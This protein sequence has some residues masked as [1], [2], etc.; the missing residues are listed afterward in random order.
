MSNAGTSQ[1]NEWRFVSPI[2]IHTLTQ[3]PVSCGRFD[4]Y[5]ELFW[6]GSSNG[7]V[8]S[9][10]PM[11]NFTR[12][13][14]FVVSK[15]S[16]VHHIEPTENAIFTLTDTVLRAT[17][18]QG[19]PL[20]AYS[21]STMERMMALCRLPG[22][23]TFVMGGFQD[24]L[25]L[26]DFV[27]EKE[28]RTTE[29]Q[30]EETAIVIRYNG[31]NTYSADAKGRIHVKNPKN[32]E[33][34]Q[35][36]GCHNE[37]VLDFDVQGSMMV[38][39]GV[40]LANSSRNSDKFLKVYDLRMNKHLPP[41]SI[42]NS[43]QFVRFIPSY[44][45]R[46]AVVYQTFYNQDGLDF[47][48]NCWNNHPAGI[49]MFDL[50]AP[51]SP[52]EFPIETSLVTSFDYSST[53][54]YLA[55]GNNLGFVNFFADRDQPIIN[56]NSK[57]TVFSVP[58]VQPPLSFVIDDMSHSVG[59]IPMPFPHDPLVSDWP[60]EFTQ[61]V[62]RRRKEP[63]ETKNAKSIHYATQITNP[64]IGT[65]LKLFNIVPYF[66]EQEQPPIKV[67]ADQILFDSP[68]PTIDKIKV[69]KLYKKRPPPVSQI[70]A[71][72]GKAPEEP[73]EAYTWNVIRHVTMQSTHAMNLVA[74]AVV[75]VVYYLGALRNIVLR[76]ICT[77]DSCITCEI[78][79]IFTA[80]SSKIGQD[81]GIATTNLA[82]ALARNGVS[83]KTGGVLSAIQQVI[84]IIL[85][86]VANKVLDTSSSVLT[87][88]DRHLRCIRCGELQSVEQRSEH[89]LTLNYSS[90][91]PSSFCRIL[92]K[93]LHLGAD[94]GER[95]CAEC[96]QISRMECKRKILNLSPVLLINTNTSS[97]RYLDFWQTQLSEHESRPR[98]IGS[99]AFV[100][101]SPSEKK[102]C[103]F[104]DGCRDKRSCKFV[105][106]HIDWSTE[107]TRLLDDIDGIGWN[108]YIPSRI[109]A[110]V[111]EG[112]VRITDISDVPAYEEPNA[113]IYELDAMVH[114]IG[115]GQ[116]D[117][118]WTHPVTLLRESPV[119]STA[120]TLINE[121]LVSRLHDHE[122]RHV[123]P[124]WKLPALIAYKQKGAEV[125]ITE[126][127]VSDDLFFVEKNYAIRSAESMAIKT[128]EDL[129][130]K[131]ELVGLDA[132]FIKI[133]TNL[134]EFN[135]R[136]V[137]AKALGRASCLDVTGEKVI[138]DDHIKL[139]EDLEVVDYLTKYSG[140][141]ES[142][143]CPATSDKYL[144]THKR[145]LL[146]MHVMIQ[147][148]VIF[149]GHAVHNDFSVMNVHIAEPQIIDT[150][151]LWR[152]DA[153][154]MLSLQFLVK[155]VLGESIQ[156]FSHDSV[157][158]AKYTLKLYHKYLEMKDTEIFGPEMR[159]MYAIMPSSC[160]SPNPCAS[161]LTVSTLRQATD[162]IAPP[163]PKSV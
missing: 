101:E 49:K 73:V 33:T 162:E 148:G 122:A 128:S 117:V 82:W 20:T 55:V 130:K 77:E 71:R 120:W 57:E 88:F 160:S 5:E 24:K 15:T 45:A 146:R 93:A 72:R 56:E 158:D 83:L 64:R 97:E 84:K 151:N 58:P 129:P 1:G 141:V 6:T 46:V 54:N 14:A 157:V 110:Q 145:L 154:R 42:H 10:L 16:G 76:H 60:S 81:E 121:Q 12:Y 89:L 153:Q 32:Y 111:C 59:S 53:M 114:L 116:E 22:T 105:H 123:D 34:I 68:I 35:V 80:F 112:I 163:A 134:L 143:L 51:L 136:S 156:E 133:K 150:V 25:I 28:I 144:T 9:F 43:P 102:H 62:H 39:C 118:C 113:L 2:G 78:H 52:I 36:I 63:A 127:N 92:E 139:D 95:E 61:I 109:A 131:G 152:L 104:G 69:P 138:F 4:P 7:N 137:Q 108:H 100:P 26:Y 3:N 13:T 21:A 132:E 29:L 79:F 107:Q 149:V 75:Q 40:S 96:K 74:N 37:R 142:D 90:I 85:N 44:C 41:I 23:S 8:S 140:I 38:T 87:E 99:S 147:R 19:I 103:R 126:R 124:R 135:G 30:K 106:G 119:A 155:E 27:K 31:T 17:S 70:P 98:I 11:N 67:S 86:D 66:L 65:N 161:P 91:Q 47:R 50:S 125:T 115:N 18:R 48:A 159:R 94:S